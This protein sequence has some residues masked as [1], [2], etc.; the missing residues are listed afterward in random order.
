MAR[1][2]PWWR[3][4]AKAVSDAVEAF[5]DAL[6][7]TTRPPQPPPRPT[8]RAP[9]PPRNEPPPRRPVDREPIP[10]TP[11]SSYEDLER[12]ALD[13]IDSFKLD[14]LPDRVSVDKDG[15]EHIH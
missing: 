12:A 9:E 3:R 2:A 8:P 1:K 11:E 14:E 10:V 6:S 5:T 4:L 7:G 15:K 13:R